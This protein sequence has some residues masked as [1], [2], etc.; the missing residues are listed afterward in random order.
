MHFGL[1][2]LHG[3]HHLSHGAVRQQH[4]RHAVLVRQVE[5]L[6]GQISHFLHARGGEHQHV[7]IAVAR[8]A[9]GLEVV[10]LGGLNAA[11]AG[12]AA[13]HVHHQRRKLRARHVRETLALQGD[14]RAGGGGHHAM[15]RGGHAVDHVDGG[16]F[17]LRLQEASAD[18]GHALGH[19]GGDLRLRRDGITEVVSATGLNRGLRDGFV[20]LH[21][22]LFSHVTNLTFP[23]R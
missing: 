5:A 18:F 16:D 23:L 8:A 6:D 20:A 14:S 19:V 11:Q 12:A 4:D 10:R 9:G 17:A 2:D 22:Y 3:L 13:L 1:V 7:E 15:A 21:Q